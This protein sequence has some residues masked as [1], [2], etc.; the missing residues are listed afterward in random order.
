MGRMRPAWY[1][2]RQAQEA[3]ARATYF[4]NRQPPP[5]GTTVEQRGAS[6][7]LFYRSLLQRSGT[8]S[9]IYKVSVLDSTLSRISA[10]QAG[11]KTT[12]GADEVAL[13]LRGS[14]LKPTRMHWYRGKTTPTRERSP[15]NTSWT[16][17]YDE[18]GGQSHFSIPLSKATGVFDG[19]DLLDA[20]EGLFGPTGTQRALL[21]ATNGRAYVTMEQVSNAYQS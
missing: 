3:Q 12:L 13:R 18:T 8:D 9:L 16:Q 1:Y 6:T 4:Q 17:Y 10:V 11:L 15:W 7:D 14:G 5:A 2:E 21:G 20:F 19:G